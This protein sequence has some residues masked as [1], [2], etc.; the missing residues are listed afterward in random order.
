M[1][2]RKIVANIVDPEEMRVAI[3]ENGRLVDIFIERMWERQ[4]TGEVYKARVDSVLP[5][6]H[7]AFVNLGD[8][9]NAFLYLNDAK[10]LDLKPNIEVVVQVVKAARK[11]KGARVT[12]RIS[13]PGRYLVFVPE[14]QE[15]GVSKRITDEEER[16]RLRA[17]A[18]KLRDEG[19]GYGVI[20][21][22]AA[23]GVDEEVLMHELHN[24]QDLW[25]E[26][27]HNAQVQS[28]PCLIYRDIGLVGRVLR[29]ELTGDVSEIIIDSEEEYEKVNDFLVRLLGDR[30]PEVELYQGNTPIFDFYGI[31]RDLETA[32]DRKVWLKSGA[33]LI[34]DHTEALTVIDVNTGKFVG[35]TDLRHTVLDTNLEAADEIARQLRL[36]A[37]GGIV[38]IDFI[39]MEYEE[40]RQ[41]LLKRLEEVFQSD[42]Y[43]ARIFGVSQLGLVEITRK[44]ARP[45]VRS[46]MTRGCPFCGGYGW[47]LKEDSVAMHIKRFLRK[48]ALSNKSEAMLLEA[49]P[50]IA[51]YIAETYLLL[52]EEEFGRKIFIA[53]APEFAWSKYR[54][55]VQ[56]TLDLVERKVEQMEQ[57]EAKI[58]VYRT[59]SS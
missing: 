42:R 31:E 16:K 5:G 30:A 56:G 11:N 33:Y 29:D 54:L 36:R 44:R 10:G 6:I 20:I 13:L 48:V 3:I 39:D 18:K 59:A 49:H 7:A 40:D 50:A 23:E 58:R 22:T 26:I 21:R 32:L 28:A 2:D 1:T 8:G 24:L 55:D 41:K 17:L 46:V 53:G 15:T 38:V 9:R 12:A 25:E 51:Q 19:N 34:I 4:K 57:W 35:D 14:G 37:I 43:R 27:K 52:W 45:D 47:V